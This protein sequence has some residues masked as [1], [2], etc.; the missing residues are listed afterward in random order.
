MTLW[1]KTQSARLG[2]HGNLSRPVSP[3][4]MRLAIGWASTPGRCN[5]QVVI[6]RGQ[7]QAVQHRLLKVG[8]VSDLLKPT[9]VDKHLI[10]D[11]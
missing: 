5:G 4:G 10:G 11:G 7:L 3:A 1:G 9:V 2:L 6:Y 8:Y